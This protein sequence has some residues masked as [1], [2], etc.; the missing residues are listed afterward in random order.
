MKKSFLYPTIIF[1]TSL[2]YSNHLREYFIENAEK[3]IAY[4]VLPRKGTINNFVEVYEKGVK[5]KTKEL[6]SP[7]N[8]FFWHI[9]LYVH[10]LKILFAFTRRE[11]KI[12]FINYLFTL[13]FLHPVVS[14]FRNVKTVAWVGDYWP[15]NNLSIQIYNFFLR[16]FH[17]SADYAFYQT[18]RINKKMNGRLINTERHKTIIPG[19]E[20]PKINF[21]KKIR[22]TITLCFVGVL[23]PWQG[24]D[25]LLEI[26]AKNPKIK[27]KLI[28]TGE[29]SVVNSHRALIKKYG[30]EKRV[31]FPNK[32]IYKEELKKHIQQSDIGIA[33]YE[34][35]PMK[36]TYY[37][38]PAKIKQYMEYG[39]PI[40]MTDAAEVATYIK[41]FHAGIVVERNL[42]SITKAI[43]TM[44]KNYKDYLKNLDRLNKWLNFRTYYMD[45]YKFLEEK[46]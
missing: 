17:R 15:M 41:K 22:D 46:E 14:F 39:L 18:D 38:D 30:I 2:Q 4:Y 20:V 34:V 32:F 43:E 45:A 37:G 25:V 13:Y 31:Y 10:Y 6:Y 42:E 36:V 24:V 12:Y 27:L 35:D 9:F 21:S 1:L 44:T 28:G 8:L 11:E 23:V 29:E 19:V 26:V 16:R 33:L 5:V 40:I 7:R 3:A